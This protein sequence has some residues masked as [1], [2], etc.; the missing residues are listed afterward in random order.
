MIYTKEQL[1]AEN[2]SYNAEH[3]L[4]DFDLAKVNYYKQLI[5]KNSRFSMNPQ[6]GDAVYFTDEYNHEYEKAHLED[7]PLMGGFTI[8]ERPYT[9]FVSNEAKT[10][11]ASGGA[12]TSC[13]TAEFDRIGDTE[14]LFCTWGHRGMTGNG[15][16][17][18]KATVAH[19]K[20][21]KTNT[22]GE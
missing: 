22:K 12:W 14:K 5:E 1:I 4:D 20:Y 3:N 16:I 10:F 21:I 11:R 6:S 2:E 19:W 18:V 9:P 15:A 8:C 13:N 7:N 17:Y